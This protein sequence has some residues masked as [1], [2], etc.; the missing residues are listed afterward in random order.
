LASKLT[1]SNPK[2]CVVFEDS[3]AGIIAGNK[4]NMTTIGIGKSS[5]LKIANKVFEKFEEIN[6]NDFK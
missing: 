6:L 1:N 4:I 3:E 2:N 5:K